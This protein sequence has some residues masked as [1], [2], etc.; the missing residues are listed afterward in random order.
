MYDF[1]YDYIKVKY[2]DKGKLFTDTDRLCYEIKTEDFYADSS[3]NIESRFDTSEYPTDHP[4][5]TNGFPVGKNKKVIEM[6]KDEMWDCKQIE[7]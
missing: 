3:S 7:E 5:V 4:A 6:L 2:G 1:Q